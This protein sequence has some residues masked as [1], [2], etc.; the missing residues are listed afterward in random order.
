MS[1]SQSIRWG[2]IGCRDVTEVKSEPVY[3]L[4]EGFELSAVMSRD[5]QKLKDYAQ[6]HQIDHL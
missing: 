4:T 5:K 6:R 3:K 1:S 2:I